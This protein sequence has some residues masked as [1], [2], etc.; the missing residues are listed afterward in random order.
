L[1]GV[2]SE[3]MQQAQVS[4][5]ANEGHARGISGRWAEKR[6]KLVMSATG[7]GPGERPTVPR[8][9]SAVLNDKFAAWRM[10]PLTVADGRH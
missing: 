8:I 5:I 3:L 9:G 2:G 1:D 4:F 10:S 6:T 7:V